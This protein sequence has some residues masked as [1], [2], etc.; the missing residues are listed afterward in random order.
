[1]NIV[2]IINIKFLSCCIG[3]MA[4]ELFASGR[5]T[6]ALEALEREEGGEWVCCNRGVI[7]FQLEL[8]RAAIKQCDRAL[9]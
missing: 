1:M 8:Y 3:P 9:R 4:G 6:E 5:Y 7:N 2:A